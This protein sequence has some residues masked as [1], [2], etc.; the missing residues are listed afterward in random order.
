MRSERGRKKKLIVAFHFH[1]KHPAGWR[2]DDCRKQRLEASRRCGFLPQDRR[3]SERLVWIG[4]SIA[5]SECPTSYVTAESLAFLE[6]FVAWSLSRDSLTTFPA[7]YAD[8]IVAL[9]S[10]LRKARVDG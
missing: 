5:I 4:P 3:G 9:N 10:E 6:A 1:Q 8:A 7:R 2:C